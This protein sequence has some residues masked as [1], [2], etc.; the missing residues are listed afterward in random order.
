MPAHSITRLNTLGGRW[1]SIHAE[2]FDQQ[3]CL[4]LIVACM[5]MGRIVFPEMHEDDNTKKTGDLRHR[6]FLHTVLKLVT[7]LVLKIWTA[8]ALSWSLPATAATVASWNP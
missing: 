2:R 7:P 8:F 3:R 1:P 5:K 6:S 4:K